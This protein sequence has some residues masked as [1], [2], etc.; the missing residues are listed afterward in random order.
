MKKIFYVL[1][2]VIVFA[3]SIAFAKIYELKRH[4]FDNSLPYK[5]LQ[6]EVLDNK[7][8]PIENNNG[9]KLYNYHK[10]INEI[11]KASSITIDKQG[12][13]LAEGYET[14]N[15]EPDKEVTY[16]EFIKMAISLANNRSF[17]YSIFPSPDPAEGITKHWAAPYVVVAEMQDVIEVGEINSENIDTPIN[18][19]EMIR[20]LSKIQI[21]MKGIPQFTDGFL[22]N[23]TDITMIGKENEDLL[24]HAA[25]YDMIEGMYNPDS[26]SDGRE[27]KL[28]PY[29]NITRAEA[30]RALLRVY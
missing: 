23:Y 21:N 13:K 15:F 24:L 26:D 18:R 1:V 3:S 28:E 4:T 11:L 14:G 9:E 7:G 17:D 27:L 6:S 29:K 16:G 10:Y 19:L 20:I 25:K 5:D 8:K 30:V 12:H 2:A 22:P